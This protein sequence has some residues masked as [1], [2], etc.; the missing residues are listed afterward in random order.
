MARKIRIKYKYRPKYLHRYAKGSFV[1]FLGMI[2]F[3]SG[4]KDVGKVFIGL[5]QALVF[6]VFFLAKAKASADHLLEEFDVYNTGFEFPK[7]GLL[8]DSRGY[9]NY[10]DVKNIDLIDDYLTIKMKSGKFYEIPLS[11]I[12]YVGRL[13]FAEELMQYKKNYEEYRQRRRTVNR[14][15]RQAKRLERQKKQ[16]A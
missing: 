4:A 3:F 5:T 12:S 2:L 15:K 1:L 11:R 16:A 10:K 7:V 14:R 8:T 6:G 13:S 9:A